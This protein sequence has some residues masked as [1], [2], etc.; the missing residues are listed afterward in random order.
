MTK[1]KS[2]TEKHT[3]EEIRC[4]IAAIKDKKGEAIRVLDVRGKSSITDYIVLATG[5]SDP[6]VKALKSGLDQ[7]LNEAN[8]QLIGQDRTLGSGWLVVDAFDFMI[9]LQTS[10][11]RD[12]Y[13]LDQLWKDA[14]EVNFQS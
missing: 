14:D 10:E 6:H 8:V 7:A 1:E 13:R 4:A 9:H 11:M 2:K 12:F 5:T 3:L